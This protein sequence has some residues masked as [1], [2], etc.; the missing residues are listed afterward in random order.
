MLTSIRNNFFASK[1]KRK[2]EKV[3][4]VADWASN[5]FYKCKRG[6]KLSGDAPTNDLALIQTQTFL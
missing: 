2:T 5:H 1:C 3:E 4:I 6:I